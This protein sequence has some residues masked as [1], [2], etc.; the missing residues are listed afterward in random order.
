MHVRVIAV[1]RLK[2]GPERDLVERYSSRAV[3]L[4]RSLGFA[5]P[6]LVE[7]PEARDRRGEDRQADEAVRLR[8]RAGP[9]L[10][11]LLDERAPTLS[12]DAFADRLA[13]LRDGGRASLAFLIGGPDGFDAGLRDAAEWPLS[14]GR[15]TL[16]HQIVRVLVLEQVY[17][18]FTI[19]AGHPYHRS[20]GGEG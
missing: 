3:A 1:G 11:A 17:R 16:P 5:G 15:L 18:A 13:A 19:M 8:E 6:D 12:S 14:F 2:A 4:G 9:S 10:V 20:G 7:L